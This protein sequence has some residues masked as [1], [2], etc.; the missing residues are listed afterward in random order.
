MTQFAPSSPNLEEF[1]VQMRW[2]GIPL[3]SIGNLPYF[4]DTMA[5]K[6]ALY[7]PDVGY[8]CIYLNTKGQ[9]IPCSYV[10]DDYE[11]S[12]YG[13]KVIIPLGEVVSWIQSI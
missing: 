12:F 3:N 1:F 5:K 10:G 2:N 13:H 11:G 9:L 4:I 7:M 6:Y 8:K